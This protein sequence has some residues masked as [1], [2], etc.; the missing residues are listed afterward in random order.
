MG[1][2]IGLWNEKKKSQNW[3]GGG[4]GKWCAVARSQVQAMGA[5]ESP[6]DKYCV[7]WRERDMERR[8]GQVRLEG[9]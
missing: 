9:G 8:Q 5:D 6:T 4:G 2:A 7:T 3:V 1:W